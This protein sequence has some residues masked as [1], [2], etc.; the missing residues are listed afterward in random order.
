MPKSLPFQPFPSL[1]KLLIHYDL[2][3]KKKFS[4]NFIIDWNILHKI[5][6]YIPQERYIVEIGPGHTGLT[7][8]LLHHSKA[9]IHAIEKDPRCEVILH[10]LQTMY[11]TRF[12]FAMQDALKEELPSF[13][14][15]DESHPS[16]CPAPIHI[17]SNLP[18]HIATPL[19]LKW[20]AIP[21]IHSIS[22][23]L[24]KEVA[25]RLTSL[26]NCSSYGRLSIL[27][28]WLYQIEHRWDISPHV[29]IPPPQVDSS[30]IQLTRRDPV[31]FPTSQK[32][33]EII[34]HLAFQQRRKMIK[35]SL[36]SLPIEILC[37][38]T[39]IP[40]TARPQEISVENFCRLA[41]SLMVYSNNS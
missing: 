12:S 6:Q 33:L 23:M 2:Y 40:L 24:Q 29:F 17:V 9:H 41:N 25:L 38:Q 3:G 18:Y 39:H 14:N 8:S 1:K 32:H 5:A 31:L 19:L 28:Q 10:D 20:S 16:P 35:S 22:V 26:P 37:A 7:R 4:Q 27:M 13:H 34:T 30:F 21:W 36:Q 11:P 15:P